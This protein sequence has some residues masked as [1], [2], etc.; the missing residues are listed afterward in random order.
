V[1]APGR[2]LQLWALVLLAASLAALPTELLGQLGYDHAVAVS[3]VMAL[4]LPHVAA[5]QVAASR[6]DR[7]PVRRREGFDYVLAAHARLVGA[8]GLLLAVPLMVVLVRGVWTPH[9]D[10]REGILWYVLLPGVTSIYVVSVSLFVALASRRPLTAVLLTYGFFAVT[11]AVA[12][13]HLVVDP[14]LFAFTSVVGYIA[15]PIYDE[16]VTVVPALL[17][18]RAGTL[19]W[20]QAFLLATMAA[21]DPKR[22]RIDPM[23]LLQLDYSFENLTPRLGLVLSVA[24]IVVLHGLG[25]TNGTAPTAA[26]IQEKLGGRIQTDNFR[27]YYDRDA[28]DPIEARLLAEEHEFRLRQI[29]DIL[30]W[31]ELPPSERPLESYIYP[32][33]EVKKRLMGARHTSFA[34]PFDRAMHLHHQPFPHP[35]LKHELAHLV[36]ASFAGWLGF[37]PR[38]GWHEGFAVAVDWEEDRLTPDQWTQAMRVE[39]LLP[40]MNAAMSAHGFW[41]QPASRAYLSMGSLS[42]Y[43]MDVHGADAFVDFFGD[44]DP[45]QHFGRPLDDLLAGWHAHLDSVPLSDADRAF[46]RARL[47][48]GAIFDRRCAREAA[49]IS[50]RA[51]DDLARRRHADALERFDRLAGWAPD[52]P[53]P[54]LGR[55]RALIGL[56]RSDE[57]TVLARSLVTRDDIG[58]QLVDTARDALGD[59]AWRRGDLA[60]ARRAFEELSRDGAQPSLVRGAFL[61]L[62]VLE[63]P[64]YRRV[65][66]DEVGAVEASALLARL[67]LTGPEA[68]IAHYLLGRRLHASGAMTTAAEH[69]LSATTGDLVDP[70]VA[71]ECRWL[72]GEALYREGNLSGAVEVYEE[73]GLDARFP[74]ERIRAEAWLARCRWRTTAPSVTMEGPP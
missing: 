7:S 72:L 24:G 19:L 9:C 2:A 25:T 28:L 71:I 57:A 6:R 23:Q 17:W 13:R 50:D 8:A 45:E 51:W 58:A 5:S 67:S 44:P 41:T 64:T 31:T 4:I 63:D 3:V 11:L 46:A 52:D 16:R 54:Q 74:A 1:I 62:R 48:R 53:S 20:A 59:I 65:F 60:A 39:D 33:P 29:L 43:L 26:S 38:I 42:R 68:A 14:P 56:G 55:L 27:I 22:H 10:L 69:L 34:D 32:S 15:G 18:G 36:S 12:V 35:V 21:C 70:A 40:D 30:G 66:E 73:I 47:Q 37:N 61:K 49:E